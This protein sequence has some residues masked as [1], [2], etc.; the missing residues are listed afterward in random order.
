MKIQEKCGALLN[1]CTNL[2]ITSCYSDVIAELDSEKAILFNVSNQG[3]D[4]GGKLASLQYYFNYCTKTD[5][6]FLLHDKISIQSLNA[7]YWYDKLYAVFSDEFIEST[8]SSFSDQK[9]GMVGAKEFLMNEYDP[10]EKVFRTTNN[11]I[12][13]QLLSGYDLKPESYEFIAGSIFATRSKILEEFFKNKSPLKVRSTL[14]RGNVIDLYEGTYTH[15]WERLFA[16]IIS[17]YGYTV[18]GL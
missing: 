6:L 1:K 11:K 5:L 3:K 14:E 12:L 10:S 15:S 9:T 17:S 18:K 4:I 16:F 13:K 2:L 8:I 7:A